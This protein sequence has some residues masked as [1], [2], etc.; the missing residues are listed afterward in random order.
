MPQLP[1]K[2]TPVGKGWVQATQFI[3]GCRG[4]GRRCPLSSRRDVQARDRG[5]VTAPEFPACRRLPPQAAA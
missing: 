5:D 4:S 2:R 3:G 1:Q